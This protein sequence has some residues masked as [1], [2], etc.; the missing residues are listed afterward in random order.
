M[1]IPIFVNEPTILIQDI[2]EIFPKDEMTYDQKINAITRLV[3]LL[4]SLGFIFTMKP[5][6]L[7]MGIVTLI[8][9]AGLYKWKSEPI[10]F[11]EQEGFSN[12]Q[13]KKSNAVKKVDFKASLNKTN[14]NW[15]KSGTKK[16]PF[17]NVLLTEIGDDP[18]RASAPP[19]FNEKV[20][21]EITQNVKRGVQFMNPEIK[22]TSKQLYGDLWDKFELDQSNRAFFS[23]ANTQVMADQSAFSQFLYGDMISAKEQ[24]ADGAIARTQ[25]NARHRLY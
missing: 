12:L 14:G 1:N 13:K 11:A 10:S 16:N 19:A 25:D 5:R 3:I 2:T 20:D 23:T 24:N 8:L 9:I 21:E 6:F 15:F 18:K 22:S 4:S 7:I 17:S